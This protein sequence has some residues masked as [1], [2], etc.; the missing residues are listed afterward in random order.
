MQVVNWLQLKPTTHDWEQ[1][2]QNLN[3]VIH[4]RT[5]VQSLVR[6]I[7]QGYPWEGR[8][9]LIPVFDPSQTFEVN[10]FEGLRR[11]ENR[12]K[13]SP[14]LPGITLQD[15]TNQGLNQGPDMNN[16]I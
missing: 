4:V 10:D 9:D 16:P 6:S 11:I 15:R 5:L 13:I 1:A 12:N 14:T 3:G 2:T 7:L 8:T